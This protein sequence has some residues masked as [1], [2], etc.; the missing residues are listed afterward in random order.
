[1]YEADYNY[2]E[3]IF[4]LTLTHFGED[5]SAADQNYAA[6]N[7]EGVRKAIHKIKSTFGF[8]GMMELQENCRKMED[9]CIS[10]HSLDEIKGEIESLLKQ[11]NIHRLILQNEY[12]RLK[13]FN[14]QL[15]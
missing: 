9:K 13:N 4:N 14:S 1:M 2:I 8:I 15:L 11:I 5:I 3:Q 12:V 10:A 6:A 7:M